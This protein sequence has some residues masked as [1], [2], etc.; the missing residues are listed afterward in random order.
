MAE[1]KKTAETVVATN[2]FV[3]CVQAFFEI[4]GKPRNYL[5]LNLPGGGE[6]VLMIARRVSDDKLAFVWNMRASADLN[7]YPV[8]PG[9]LKNHVTGE[10]LSDAARRELLEEIGMDADQIVDI[11]MV[12]VHPLVRDC[13]HIYLID[14]CH[15]PTT[16]T[17]ID[18][19]T[20]G[21]EWLNSEEAEERILDGQSLAALA[22]LRAYDRKMAKTLLKGCLNTD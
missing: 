18:P 12:D 7:L 4:D 11:G 15:P 8:L 5:L 13:V 14:D 22:K 16:E 1:V 9:G 6:S 3:E 19:E 20:L 2:G 10:G 21:I 17:G